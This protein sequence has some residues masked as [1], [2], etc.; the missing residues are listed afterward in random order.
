MIFFTR[1]QCALCHLGTNFT[2]NDFHSVATG[3]PTDLGRYNVT[4]DEEDKG[5]FKV[6]SLRNW[7]DRE[8]FLHDGRFPTLRE[9][10]GHYSE[11]PEAEA[12]ESELDPLDLSDSEKNDLAAF[13]EALNG[14]W[15]DLAA[16]E[17]AWRE[18]AGH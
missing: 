7:K 3:S 1:G 17:E 9:V 12:G 13:L 14:P 4:G 11:P 16:F 5:K 15:P 10:I 6:P 18:L 2:D 8:P